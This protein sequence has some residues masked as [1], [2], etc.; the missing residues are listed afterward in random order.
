MLP[1]ERTEIKKQTLAFIIASLLNVALLFL[2]FLGELNKNTIFNESS[3]YEKDIVVDFLHEQTQSIDEQPEPIAIDKKQENDAGLMIRGTPD[4]TMPPSLFSHYQTYA[5]VADNVAEKIVEQNDDEENS[6]KKSSNA[7]QSV[8]PQ[9]EA[10]APNLS[11]SST[12]K[13]NISHRRRFRKKQH[14]SNSTPSLAQIT[15]NALQTF[16]TTVQTKG[17]AA[18]FMSGDANK[19]PSELQLIEEYYWTKM[20]K[21]WQNSF[22]LL[23]DQLTDA[24]HG[25]ITAIVELLYQPDGYI[26]QVYM[27]RSS[28]SANVDQFILNVFHDALPSFPPK[29]TRLRK[30]HY[31]KKQCTIYLHFT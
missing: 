15:R 8:I 9:N 20:E 4:G 22:T 27:I 1:V 12:T 25:T 11:V 30:P 2:I 29:P 7:K 26:K 10:S 13:K 16:H 28:G 6:N 5:T 18:I 21:V 31:E 24:P 14:L 19:L 17:N 3:F 23:Q